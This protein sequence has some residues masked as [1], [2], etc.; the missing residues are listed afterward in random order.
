MWELVRVG[1]SVPPG[2]SGKQARGTL[3]GLGAG[4]KV[5][6]RRRRGGRVGGL[7]WVVRPRARSD[8]LAGSFCCALVLGF[9]S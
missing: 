3:A 5:D 9:S 7:Y 2:C 8:F 4:G 1:R 6:R